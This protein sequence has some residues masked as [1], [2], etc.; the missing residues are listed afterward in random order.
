MKSEK[1]YLSKPTNSP[2]YQVI[3]FDET[4]KRKTKS[5]KQTTK[6]AALKFLSSFNPD[7]RAEGNN[8]L[9]S[10]LKE[11]Y[12]DYI[13]KRSTKNYQISVG[14][15]FRQLLLFTG[16]MQIK[17]FLPYTAENFILTVFKRSKSAAALYHRTL[18]AAFNKAIVWGF[19]SDNPFTTFK[20]PRIPTSYPAFISEKELKIILDNT[21]K[22]YMKD[23]FTAAFCTG[24]RLSELI[25]LTWRAIDLENE[26]LIVLNTDSFTTKGKRER[27]IPLNL[28]MLQLL[29]RKYG[30]GKDPD[31]IIFYKIKDVKLNQDYISK[32]FKKAVRKSNLNDNL[33][34]H[35][36]RHSF[37]SLLVQRGASIYVVKELLG[38]TDIKTTQIYCHLEHNNLA[39]IIDLIGK[40]IY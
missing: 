28:A 22:Q 37:A 25:N 38:H 20:L 7:S 11:K 36:L 34:F 26:I 17:D 24:L 1:L 30:K 29:K 23:I 39:Q 6:A 33:K 35:S 8:N 5:T 40:N 27:I 21:E 19:T 4:G 9:L 2:Y 32:T 15:S 16:D 13:I 18:K 12:L 3:W 14:L 31:S 10:D